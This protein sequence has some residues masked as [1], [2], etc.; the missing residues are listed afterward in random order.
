[1]N[2]LFKTQSNSINKTNYN[3][4]GVKF[5]LSGRIRGK[6]R[7][8]SNL[9]QIGSVPTQTISK[10]I[11]YATSHVYTLYGVFGIKVWTYFKKL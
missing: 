5:L 6:S 4:C 9:I 7:S 8:S 10:T 11:D 2:I 1:M 3:L